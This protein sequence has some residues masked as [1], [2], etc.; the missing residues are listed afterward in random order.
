MERGN[1]A[2]L[3]GASEEFK[4]KAGA[5]GKKNKEEGMMIRGKNGEAA[6]ERSVGMAQEKFWRKKRKGLLT[7]CFFEGGEKSKGTSNPVL[8]V[9]TTTP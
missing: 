9:K 7:T 8:T 3:E 1:K 4:E 5:D 2:P 6:L